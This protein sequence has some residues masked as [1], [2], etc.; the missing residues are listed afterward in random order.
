VVRRVVNWVD[1]VAR[2]KPDLRRTLTRAEFVPGG[3]MGPAK[4]G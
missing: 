2:G 1:H 3:L 4:Q